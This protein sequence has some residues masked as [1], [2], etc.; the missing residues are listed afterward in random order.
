VTDRGEFTASANL[1]A[2]WRKRERLKM[3]LIELRNTSPRARLWHKRNNVTPANSQGVFNADILP[4]HSIR[5]FGVMTN[6]VNGPQNFDKVFKLGDQ[7][8]Y[9]SFNLIYTGKIVRIGPKTVTI[10]HYDHSDTVT[11]L[12]VHWFADKNWD[13]DA[14]KIAKHNSEESQYL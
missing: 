11:Q 12:D 6:H 14:D 3:K 9:D 13:F 1:R 7:A 2:I 10:K 4:G 5:I 8:E